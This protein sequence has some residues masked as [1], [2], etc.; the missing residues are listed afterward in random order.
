MCVPFDLF[1]SVLTLGLQ[2]YINFSIYCNL[3]SGDAKIVVRSD[4]LIPQHVLNLVSEVLFSI[5]LYS[6]M[7]YLAVPAAP[8]LVPNKRAKSE[9][10]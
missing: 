5:I 2:R 6:S 9:V 4:V 3:S 8:V 1:L 10:W 7:A